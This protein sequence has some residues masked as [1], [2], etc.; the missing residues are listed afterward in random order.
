M[1]VPLVHR[2]LRVVTPRFLELAHEEGHVV[3]VWTINDPAQMHRLLDAGVDGLVTDVPALA[4]QVFRERGLD[5]S[6]TT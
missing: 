4:A 3:H 1:Q 2:G 5:P 6:P